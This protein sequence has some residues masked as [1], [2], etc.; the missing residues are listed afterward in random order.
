MVKTISLGAIEQNPRGVFERLRR[1]DYVV[2][3][4]NGNIIAGILDADEMEDF[5][6]INDKL[7]QMQIKRGYREFRG[8]KSRPAR[9][10]LKELAVVKR[11]DF[12]AFQ[13]WQ[14]EVSDVLARVSRGRKEYQIGKT[15][16]LS[17]PRKLL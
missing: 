4:K 15:R 5:L 14:F 13:K 8:G 7:T 11:R 3:K 2:V 10:F 1:G 9:L 16:V 6:E 17:S 12:N